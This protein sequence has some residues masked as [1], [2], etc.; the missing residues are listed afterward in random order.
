MFGKEFAVIP[1]GLD[2]MP[3]GPALGAILASIDV[4]ALSG[5]DRV[6]VLRAQQR[7]A[8]HFQAQV[9]A[10]MAAVA[11]HMDR[12][13][14]AEDP[15]LAWEAAATEIRA[16]LRLTRRAAESELDV[17]VAVRRRLPGVW[18]ALRTGSIDGRRARVIAHGTSHL[19]EETARRVVDTVIE[20]APHFTTGELGALVRKLSV[21][22]DPDSAKERYAE[23]VDGR[24]VVTE[25]TPDGTAHLLGMDLPPDRVAA[26]ADR[27]NRL[28]MSLNRSGDPRSIDQ[29]RADVFLDLLAGTNR[30]AKGGTIDL[31][32]DLET[33]ARLAKTPGDLAG[34]GPVIADIA[35]QVAESQ[36]KG[37]WRYTVT[38]PDTGLPI[39][40]GTT[41]RRPTPSQR[42]TVESR[43]QVCYFPGCR[44]PATDCD[45]DHRTPWAERRRT[46]ADGL[47]AG[48][49]HDHVTVR[50]RIGWIHRLLPGGD[51]LWISPLGHR[52]TKSGLPP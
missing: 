19:D 36:R 7:M 27:I 5:H 30:A 45:L 20:D 18:I 48:C 34:F 12:V 3:T 16:A 50:H 24:R 37:E 14:F 43:D 22:V 32:V 23:A 9:Y 1:E 15:A 29:L 39:D 28:A 44:M 52:Y 17:A 35:R 2:L 4:D 47:D 40:G 33:L 25:A 31:R 38:D 13:E 46:S 49:R 21:A 8:S 41:R 10:A 6:V 51:H 26:V 42:R 11:D